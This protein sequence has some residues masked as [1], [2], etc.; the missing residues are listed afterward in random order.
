MC[1]ITFAYQS[2]PEYSFILLANRDEFYARPS[3]SMH[4]WQDHPEVL[5]GRDLEQGGTWLG[6]NQTGRFAAVTNYRDG[7][8]RKADGITRGDLTRSYLIKTESA[9]GYID[10]LEENK[11]LYGDFN[12]LLGDRQG[13]YYCSNR[14]E[15][16]RALSAGIYGMSNALLDTPWPKLEY[17]K[18]KLQA[19]LTNP[20]LSESDL[21]EI[22]LNP[23]TARDEH[24]PDTGVSLEWE[25]LLSSC[26]I[27]AEN[28]G[29]RATTLILQKPSGETVITELSFDQHGKTEQKTFALNVDPIGANPE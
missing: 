12:L 21:I 7:R 10:R 24:L 3:Q 27:Q 14:G 20:T 11:N 19:L 2:H 5:A 13:L 18:A 6:I 23:S 17:A 28:Y 8:N 16:S 9:G 4:F 25:R 22:M 1:L 26:F 29:T 15:K